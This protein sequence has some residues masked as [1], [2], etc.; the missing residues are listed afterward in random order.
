MFMRRSIANRLL[1]MCVFQH[2]VNNIYPTHK[3]VNYSPANRMPCAITENHSQCCSK[4]NSRLYSRSLEFFFFIFLSYVVITHNSKIFS[5]KLHIF[6]DIIHSQD[7]FSHNII[8]F[9]NSVLASVYPSRSFL[10]FGRSDCF[11]SSYS[12]AAAGCSII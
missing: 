4:G 11:N 3:S 6:S 2:E 9:T 5:V 7:G 10:Y 12:L 8:F 1:L